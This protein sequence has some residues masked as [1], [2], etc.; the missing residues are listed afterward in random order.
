MDVISSD[1]YRHCPLTSTNDRSLYRIS[2]KAVC[3]ISVFLT[4]AFTTSPD[5]YQHTAASHVLLSGSLGAILQ[6]RQR[7]AFKVTD[8]YVT[9]RYILLRT[10]RH[11]WRMCDWNF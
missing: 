1:Y 3:L 5:N 6:Q 10:D 11:Y 7:A 9:L 2:L 4:L 8:I